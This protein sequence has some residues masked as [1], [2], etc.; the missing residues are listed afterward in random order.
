MK[1]ELIHGTPVRCYCLPQVGGRQGWDDYTVVYM[2]TRG[3]A[4]VGRSDLY[5]CVGMSG[6]GAAM[7]GVH[8]GKRIAFA[9]LP[10]QLRRVV[11]SDIT[12][13]S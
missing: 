13:V 9:D 6:H 1:T 8:L 7:V 10:E 2:N 3:Q 4:V 11:L 12:G 5:E